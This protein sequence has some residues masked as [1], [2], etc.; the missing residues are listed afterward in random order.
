MLRNRFG[1]LVSAEIFQLRKRVSTW[2]LLG[3]WCGLA[4][5][6]GY[7]VPYFGLAEEGPVSQRLAPMLPDQIVSTMLD[8]VPFFGGAIAL[9]LGVMT[10]G[11]EFGWDTFKTLFTQR[12]GRGKVF[13]AKMAALGV[14][15]VPFVAVMFACGAVAS[16]LI[17]LAEGATIDWPSAAT[18]LQGI[19]AGWLIL[20]VWAAIGVI[21]AVATRG[22]SLAI[23]IGILYTLV[24]EGLLSALAGSFSL[25][26]PLVDF[27]VRANAYSLVK[28]LGGASAGDAPG[29]AA[30][31]GPG[32]FSG[33]FV[34]W[35]QSAVVLVAYLAL[36]LGASAWMMRRRDVA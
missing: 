14:A 16:T 15:L 26:E 8:G 31:D 12:P 30:T 2:V 28:P 1:S 32:A 7:I 34:D 19:G 36:L 17:A 9:I 13:A 18:L 11:G 20:A 6:F 4:L 25:L 24:I 5:L 27:F 22:T 33:P 23:G 3:T 21:L 10:V 35:Q 29:S